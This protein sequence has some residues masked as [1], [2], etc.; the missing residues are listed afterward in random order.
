[1]RRALVTDLALAGHEVVTT[2]DPRFPLAASRDV[3]IV[4]WADG[5]TSLER[6][7]TSVEAVWLVAPET[8]RI[9]EGLAA[10]V[11]RVGRLLVGP[12]AP[13]IRRACD[14]R[15]LAARL[16]R[17]GVPHPRT[18]DGDPLAGSSAWAG[19]AHRIGYP[20]VVKPA[21]GTG[22][23]GVTLVA[24]ERELRR[25]V[26]RAGRAAAGGRLVV[27]RFVPGPAASASVLVGRR[28]AAV[29]AIHAQ[30]VRAEPA[31]RYGGGRTPID[32]PGARTAERVAVR[33][34][35]AV[36]GL[37][38]IVGVDLVLAR[39]GAVVIE[40]NPRLTTAYLGLRR[41]VDA[42]IAGLVV[43][44][45]AG[46]VPVAPPLQRRVRFTAGGRVK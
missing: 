23:A 42:N 27:Q 41:A 3:E 25:A 8:D 4:A 37:R 39:S 19:V 40:V 28:G 34:C 22:C 16:A 20:L 10:R 18:A 1:M 38:G 14:K 7:A 13:A 30:D 31:F 6:L 43:G 44:V 12:R 5:S 32:H 21:T 15:G 11:E 33:A 46:R 35:M 9:L 17:H 45:C 24:H 29:L 26:A 36:R 2:V